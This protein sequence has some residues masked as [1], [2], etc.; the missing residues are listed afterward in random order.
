MTRNLVNESRAALFV[1]MLGAL[2][3]VAQEGLTG[4]WPMDEAKGRTTTC[5]GASAGRASLHGTSWHGVKGKAALGFYGRAFVELGDPEDDRFDLGAKGDFAISLWFCIAEAPAEQFTLLGKGDRGTNPKLLL[6]V[7]DTGKLLF[8]I[9][10]RKAVDVNGKTSVADGHWHHVLA[11]A[12]RDGETSLFLDG[13]LDGTAGPSADIEFGN[14]SPLV[15][16]KSHQKEAGPRRFLFGYLDDLRLYSRCLAGSDIS[17]LASAVGDRPVVKPRR[18][19]AEAKSKTP[20]LWKFV[21]PYESASPDQRWEMLA[22]GQGEMCG[23][24]TT[25]SAIL[26]SRL[27]WGK[28]LIHGDLPGC[29]GVGRFE[30][31]TDAGFAKATVSPWLEARPER[32]FILKHCL[33][34]LRAGTRYYY[35]LQFGL[36]SGRTKHGRV[37]TFRTLSGKTRSERVRI[38]VVTGMNYHGFHYGRPGRRYEGDDKALGYPA[39]ASMLALE[40]DYFVG[41]GDNVYYDAGLLARTQAELRA[42]WH[43]QLRQPRFVNLFANVATY[44]E[45]DDHDYRYNDADTTG[46]RSPSHELGITTFL[47]QVPVVDPKA[48]NAVTYRTHRLTRELQVWFVEG[49][50]Y[51]SPNRTP[52][53]PEKTLWGSEQMTWLKGTLSASDATFRVLIN[54]TPTI[55]PDRSSKID[56]HANPGGF[57]HEGR[58][59]IQWLTEHGFLSK[60]FYFVCGDRH[61]QYLSIDPSGFEEFSCGALVDANAIVGTFPGNPKSNDPEGK[62]KQP[63]HPRVASGGFLLITSEPPG[64]AEPATLIFAFHDEQGSLLHEV[65]KTLE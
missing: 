65:R 23:E 19:P 11:Q 48:K 53:G 51:R 9:A 57:L 16:G 29:P 63:Y 62:I 44:W 54:P 27:T 45:K 17:S 52:V 55:G 30:V 3:A 6:K 46:N 4:H 28:E 35:R 31:H 61:W 12:D 2:G 24:V 37:C 22:N 36:D 42:K 20:L 10:A 59:F 58:A 33:T 32:D 39:L 1:V 18:I 56:N 47:E 21:K 34:E 60:G 43:E 14:D 26:Q 49:R 50:D 38:A 64:Q 7:M 40:P 15:L 41:T 8:R 25:T 13:K 5:A